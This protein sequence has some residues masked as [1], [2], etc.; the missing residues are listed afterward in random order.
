[1]TLASKQGCTQAATLQLAHL[2][3]TQMYLGSLAL[4][5]ACAAAW[6]RQAQQAV[7]QGLHQ[8]LPL[9]LVHLRISRLHAC[10]AQ[11]GMSGCAG[12]MVTALIKVNPEQAPEQ[13]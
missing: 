5:L 6:Q 12:T 1:M 10:T 13:Q 3:S 9:L 4:L 8:L 2:R 7:Q 11:A